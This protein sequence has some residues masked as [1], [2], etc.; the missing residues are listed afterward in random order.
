MAASGVGAAVAL[1]TI[2]DELPGSVVF[3]GTPAEE[4]GCGKAQMIDDGLFKELDAALMF[5]PG[6][7][8]VVCGTNDSSLESEDFLV[9]HSGHATHAATDPWNGHNALDGLVSL[10]VSAAM[11]RQRLRPMPASTLLFVR[12]GRR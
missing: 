9:S 5:H 8:T 3:I 12:V 1:A 6:D 10:Y 7:R 2:K 11:W 4:V